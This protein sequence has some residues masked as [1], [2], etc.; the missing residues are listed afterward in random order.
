MFETDKLTGGLLIGEFLEKQVAVVLNTV[1]HKNLGGP[2]V[3]S[4]RVR[5]QIVLLLLWSIKAMLLRGHRIT[6]K[7]LE[8][9]RMI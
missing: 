1:C 5:E 7:F 3:S 8:E 4:E 6:E 2:S 9:V